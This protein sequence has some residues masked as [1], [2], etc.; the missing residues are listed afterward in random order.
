MLVVLMGSA[1]L[2]ILILVFSDSLH[3]S[4]HAEQ[5]SSII[6]TSASSGTSEQGSGLVQSRVAASPQHYIYIYTGPRV[7]LR[8]PVAHVRH[9][10]I[11]TR[12]YICTTR[13]WYTAHARGRARAR[14]LYC[15]HA[16]AQCP[17]VRGH[18][19]PYMWYGGWYPP[20][21]TRLLY[22]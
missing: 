8:V 13:V 2:G 7:P 18:P 19:V 12:V 9:L 14:A 5:Y 10:Y 20:G 1:S 4:V 22:I 3:V 6:S 21:T 15:A 11:H 17:R 16:C